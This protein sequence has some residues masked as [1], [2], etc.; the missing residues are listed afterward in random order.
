MSKCE[1]Y[2]TEIK[3]VRADNV[4]GGRAANPPKRV[5]LPW[6]AHAASPVPRQVASA[7]AGGAKLLACGGDLAVCPIA[8]K[9]G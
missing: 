3:M 2:R 4:H 1:F 5:A 7:A 6:C 9:L 8:D